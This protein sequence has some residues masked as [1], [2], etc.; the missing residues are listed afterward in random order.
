MRCSFLFILFRGSILVSIKSCQDSKTNLLSLSLSLSLLFIDKWRRFVGAHT[1]GGLN[2]SASHR[3][4]SNNFVRHFPCKYLHQFTSSP[5]SN[6]SSPKEFFLSLSLVYASC[7]MRCCTE[8]WTQKVG[9]ALI[10]TCKRGNRRKKAHYSPFLVYIFP[11]ALSSFPFF[12]SL[13]LPLFLILSPSCLLFHTTFMVISQ[14][15]NTPELVLIY[16]PP[17]NVY[18]YTTPRS[19]RKLWIEFHSC[20]KNECFFYESFFNHQC[21]QDILFKWLGT[22][23]R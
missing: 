7:K 15:P 5:T 6:S 8:L 4:V 11:I 14:Q 2:F 18:L 1:V 19:H 10:V 9:Q 22:I 21:L 3:I 16:L 20:N 13:F 12:L 23:R 17:N